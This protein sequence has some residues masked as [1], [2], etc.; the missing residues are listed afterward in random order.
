MGHA[1]NAQHY[2]ILQRGALLPVAEIKEDGTIV[3]KEKPKVLAHE[4]GQ[5]LGLGEFF[6]GLSGHH[7]EFNSWYF[8]SN[9]YW[10][11]S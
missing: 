1:P 6:F 5:V 3:L 8:I 9:C 2:V 4:L 11:N 7:H 10:P